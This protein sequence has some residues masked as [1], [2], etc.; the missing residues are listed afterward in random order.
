[1]QL[2][3]VCI[4]SF[5]CVFIYSFMFASFVCVC[6]CVC[7]CVPVDVGACVGAYTLMGVCACEN[8]KLISV[9]SAFLRYGHCPK[10]TD[11][12]RQAGQ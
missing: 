6:V 5:V 8:Q 7:V 12:V 11:E 1:M 10:F 4:Y 3:Y 2:V 9:S